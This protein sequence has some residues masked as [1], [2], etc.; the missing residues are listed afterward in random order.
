MRTILIAD[1]HPIFRKGLAEVITSGTEYSVIGECGDG[2]SALRMIKELAPDIALLDIQMPKM[3]GFEVLK[4]VNEA[5][6][7]TNVVFL[8]M[9]SEENIFEKAMD[10]GAKGYLLKE[11][12]TDD[13]LTCL[14]NVLT[15]RFY[16]SGSISDYLVRLTTKLKAGNERTGIQKLTSTEMKVLKLIAEKLSSKEIA[17]RL[18][19]SVRTVE[20]HR[21]NICIKLDLHGANALLPFAIENKHL[22]V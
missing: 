14:K 19:V 1:D 12:V 8:T 5:H 6:L 18:F 20:N 21:N 22:L 17:E 7:T 2:I 13:I 4:A 11:S 9:H 10:L 15:G 16:V 3:T